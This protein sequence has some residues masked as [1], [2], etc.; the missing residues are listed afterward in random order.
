M[1]C[2]DDLKTLLSRYVDGELPPEERARVEEHTAACGPCRELLQIFQKNENLLSNA[3]STESFGNTVIESVMKEIKNDALP[4]EAKPVDEGATEWFRSRPI[5]PLAAAALFV[6]GLIVVLS[7]SHKSDLDNLTGQ[8]TKLSEKVNNQNILI[9]KMSE[10]AEKVHVAS[11]VED[12]TRHEQPRRMIAFIAA[13]HLVVRASFDL[14]EFG[15]FAVYRRAE[16]E[17]K[18]QFKKMN[19]D[20]RL[21][22]CEYFDTSV[23]PGQAYVYKFRAY[24]STKDDDYVESLPVTMRMPRAQELAPERSIRVQC[25][26]IGLNYKDAKFLLHRQV[27]GRTVTEEFAIKPGHKLGEIIDVPGVGKVDFRTSLTLDRLEA[28]NQTLTVSYTKAMLDANGKEVIKRFKDGTVE[29]ETEQVEGVLS[30]RPNFR[31]FFRTSG[32]AT[33]DVELWK[34]SSLFA[35]SQE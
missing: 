11:R 32:S 1:A 22:T 21:E 28:G 19:G 7:T 10:D 18:D 30:I 2:G 12:A 4:M 23:K 14:Q 35:R 17:S 16:G 26:D 25:L 33:A 24:R 3:L 29:V 27:N 9:G 34:G 15:S 6:V 31:A 8:I 5:L 20:R 13:Q